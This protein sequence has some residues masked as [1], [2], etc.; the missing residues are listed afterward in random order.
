MN[1]PPIVPTEDWQTA[2]NTLQVREKTLTR[3]LDAVAAARRRL[4]MTPVEQ[5]YV[6]EGPDGPASL[7]DLFQGRRQLIALS[8]RKGRKAEAAVGPTPG[9]AIPR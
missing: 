4:P 7:A 9:R 2:L 1:H 5:D 6:F 8:R 3:Q